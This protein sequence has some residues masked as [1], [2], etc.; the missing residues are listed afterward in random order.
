MDLKGRK[1]AMFRAHYDPSIGP[2]PQNAFMMSEP[3]SPIEECTM[4]E[5]GLYIK[6]KPVKDSK[7]GLGAEH[8]L[9][10]SIIQTIRF[11]PEEVKTK[12]PKNA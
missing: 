6:C 11:F 8:F 12:G 7:D 10:F 5:H 3:N 4:Q 2:K 1:I 9:P